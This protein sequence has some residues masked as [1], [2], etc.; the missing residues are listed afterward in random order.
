[1]ESGGRSEGTDWEEE[2]KGV[3]GGGGWGGGPKQGD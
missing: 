2:N 3:E 1:V